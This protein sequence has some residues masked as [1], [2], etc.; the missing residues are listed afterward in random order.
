ML[1]PIADRIWLRGYQPFDYH[2]LIKWYLPSHDNF[3]AST[4]I[5]FRF[6]VGCYSCTQCNR[7]WKHRIVYWT[8]NKQEDKKSWDSVN[9]FVA[10]H[11]SASTCAYSRIRIRHNFESKTSFLPKFFERFSVIIES[12]LRQSIDSS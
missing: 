9:F 8:Q 10:S 6:T 2:K 7:S 3:T 1:Q 4:T 11:Y 5:E 12:N